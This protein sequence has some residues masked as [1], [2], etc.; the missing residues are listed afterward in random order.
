MPVGEV[1][2]APFAIEEGFT[3]CSKRLDY[4]HEVAVIIYELQLNGS[5][6]ARITGDGQCSVSLIPVSFDQRLKAEALQSLRH[7]AAIP[8]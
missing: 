5:Q 8:T 1:F 4:G 7:G 2:E 3:G 6:M